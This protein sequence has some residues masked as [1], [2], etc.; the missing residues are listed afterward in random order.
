ML[1]DKV[2]FEQ[3]YQKSTELYNQKDFD[4]ALVEINAALDLNLGSGKAYFQKG[5]ILL[6]LKRYNEAT[7]AFTDAIGQDSDA[8]AR[9]YLPYKEKSAALSLEFEGYPLRYVGGHSAFLQSKDVHLRLTDSS[10]EIPEFNIIVPYEK[11]VQVNIQAK[12]INPTGQPRGLLGML[13]SDEGIAYPELFFSFMDGIGMQ[14]TMVFDSGDIN[15]IELMIYK[16][17]EAAKG[18]MPPST[19]TGSGEREVVK[20]TKV[21][22]KIR[23][24]YCRSLYDETLDKCPYCG[25]HS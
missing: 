3:H 11:V 15:N 23:C 24:S 19:L 14:Q 25:G 9:K 4:D 1:N 7:K 2:R 5:L 16:K 13:M 20:E 6:E 10:L 21:I 22:V 18:K 12:E 8:N 17:V